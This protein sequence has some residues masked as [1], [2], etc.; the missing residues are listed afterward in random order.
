MFFAKGILFV[1]GIAEAL[2][3]KE[4]AKRVIETHVDKEINSPKTLEDYGVSIINLNGIY[5]KHFMQLFQGYKLDE[6][7]KHIDGAL[8]I[9]IRCAGITDCD[10]DK[11]K[12]PTKAN[13][14]ECKNYQ[15]SLA[16][17]YKRH[18]KNCRLF[19]NLK[20]FEYDLALEG[21]NLNHM[22]EIY[23]K[24]LDTIGTTKTKLAEWLK[25]DWKNETDVIKS[26][27]ALELLNFIES[28]QN[29][30]KQVLGKGYFAQK[31]AF[32]LNE[33]IDFSIPKYIEDAILWVTDVKPKTTNV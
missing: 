1:E 13:I 7:G 33:N 28:I 30:K 21:G 4:L 15:Y 2:V 25:K 27:V 11:D 9:P 26:D 5:F 23:D 10:P 32:K 12:K 19:T 8:S 18:S 17:E 31:L 22:L 24:W 6:T 20:T 14:C 3:V 16:E 29:K